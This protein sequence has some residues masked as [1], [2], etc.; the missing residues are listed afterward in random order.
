MVPPKKGW[1]LGR[2][3]LRFG[4]AVGGCVFGLGIGFLAL[5]CMVCSLA[6]ARLGVYRQRLPLLGG[7]PLLL[8]LVCTSGIVGYLGVVPF[9]L[10][11]RQV[12]RVL[13]P[14]WF[15]LLW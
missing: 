7:R 1:W 5:R 2:W 10:C 11:G 9:A 3:W 12:F 15:P 4:V 8:G 6:L 14:C 13:W